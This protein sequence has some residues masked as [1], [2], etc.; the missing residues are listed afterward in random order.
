MV[1]AVVLGA[2]FSGTGRSGRSDGFDRRFSPAVAR[3]AANRSF[4]RRSCLSAQLALLAQPVPFRRAGGIARGEGALISQ[5]LRRRGGRRPDPYFRHE[6]CRRR[7]N[8]L[9]GLLVVVATTGMLG[10][11]PALRPT[12][13]VT[14][15]GAMLLVSYIGLLVYSRRLAVERE[16]KLHHLPE[17]F[18]PDAA[19]AIRRVAAR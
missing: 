14:I 1:W 19:A 4:D 6:A 15:I 17:R 18:E 3:V 7:R 8:V 2:A 13:F 16:A 11:V 12:L 9:V 5:G 10:V